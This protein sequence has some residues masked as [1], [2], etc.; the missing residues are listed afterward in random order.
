MTATTPTVEA[1]FETDA[2]RLLIRRLGPTTLRVDIR[3]HDVG[4]FGELPHRC[5]EALMS[6]YP[7]DLFVDAREARGASMD[8]SNAWA[9]WLGRER[10]RFAAIH[11]LPGSQYVAFTA[12]FVRRFSELEAVMHV[13]RDAAAFEQALQ[14]VMSED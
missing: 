9:A 6:P 3:G 1:R 11:M 4:E 14:S 13:H 2:C 12:Q 10:R 7:I 5:L 8:V